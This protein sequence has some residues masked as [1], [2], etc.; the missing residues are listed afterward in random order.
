MLSNR[1]LIW[2]C[3]KTTIL[4]PSLRT[5]FIKRRFLHSNRRV[6]IRWVRLTA[7]ES[8]HTSMGS[9]PLLPILQSTLTPTF[10]SRS[11][12]R[13]IQLRRPGKVSERWEPMIMIPLRSHQGFI[14]RLAQVLQ[15]PWL[16]VR[17]SDSLTISSTLRPSSLMSK[18]KWESWSVRTRSSRSSDTCTS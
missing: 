16:S 4:E 7:M 14:M 17:S 11:L 8:A 13:V 1:I 18:S 5:G 9:H 3:S 12:S 15:A 6:W 10:S 2:T